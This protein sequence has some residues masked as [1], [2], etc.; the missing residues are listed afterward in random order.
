MTHFFDAGGN[1]LAA[2]EVRQKPNLA[3][4][5]DV[6]TSVPGFGRFQGTSAAA[7]AAAGIAALIRSAKPAMAIDELYAIMTDPANAL[8]CPAPGNPD[9]ECGV[10]FVLADSALAMALDRRRRSIAPRVSPAAPDGAER[11]VPR[12]GQRDAGG[13]GSRVSGRRPG[14]LRPREPGRRSASLTCSGDQRRRDD[15]GAADASSATPTPPT[16]P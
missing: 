15:G 14:G 16:R 2:P 6:H 11:L 7:P 3:G 9:S 8:D 1:P 5:D 12:A 13:H 4:P 10:G